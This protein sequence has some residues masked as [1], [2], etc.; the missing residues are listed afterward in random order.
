IMIRFRV[1][2]SKFHRKVASS[3]EINYS[4]KAIDSKI[5]KTFPNVAGLYIVRLQGKYD[6]KSALAKL[7]NFAFV[8]YAQDLSHY[9]T[10][11][12]WALQFS[13]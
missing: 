9:K 12:A 7:D 10:V 11:P 5:I 4:V 3:G 6:M 8:I 13:E 2:N 1:K